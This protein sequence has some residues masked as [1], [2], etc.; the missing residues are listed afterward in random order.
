[1]DGTLCRCESPLP[2]PVA[3]DLSMFDHVTWGKTTPDY[4]AQER[5]FETRYPNLLEDARTKYVRAINEWVERNWGQTE[6]NE[7]SARIKVHGRNKY[8][9]K[10][11]KDIQWTETYMRDDRYDVCGDL[12]QS[13]HEADMVVGSFAIDIETPVQITYLQKDIRGQIANAFE[14]STYMYVDDTMGLQPHDKPALIPGVLE[15]IPSRRVKR[16]RWQIKGEGYRMPAQALKKHWVVAGDTLQRL[17]Q[18]YYGDVSRWPI[19]YKVNAMAIGANPYALRAGLV[20][21]IPDLNQ[22]SP[23]L[24]KSAMDNAPAAPPGPH[25]VTMP[26]PL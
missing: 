23:G 21:E 8:E 13:F 20:L 24:I 17:A 14:W 2:G 15:N 12:P 22:L 26:P 4:L 5:W 7:T 18:K 9:A 19:L 25:T 6:Y 3:P 10:I 11:N 16:A 1:M